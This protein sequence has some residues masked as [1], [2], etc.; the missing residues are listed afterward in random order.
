LILALDRDT[1]VYPAA[2]SRH[3]E[4]SRSLC[5]SHR[6]RTI[7]SFQ[8]A[9]PASHRISVGTDLTWSGLL[10]ST[11]WRKLLVGYSG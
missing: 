4:G 11:V 9:S 10:P 7:P 3:V 6:L 5:T 1:L 2:D 8:S